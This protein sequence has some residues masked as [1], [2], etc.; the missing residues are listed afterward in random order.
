[1]DIE[2]EYEQE[3][4]PRCCEKTN[5]KSW[6]FSSQGYFVPCC[7]ADTAH[8]MNKEAYSMFFKEHLHISNIQSVD[9]ILFDDGVQQFYD[10]LINRPEDAPANCKK[11]CGKGQVN[12]IHIRDDEYNDDYE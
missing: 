3:F 9:E 4:Q 2:R 1:M 12:V 10:M 6:G 11:Y 8:F 5:P 7:W